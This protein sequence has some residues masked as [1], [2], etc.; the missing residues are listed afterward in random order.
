MKRLQR[1]NGA[2]VCAIEGGVFFA[3][4]RALRTLRTPSGLRDMTISA[5]RNSQPLI[6]DVTP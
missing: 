5:I 6:L 3:A 1:E 2:W 4:S